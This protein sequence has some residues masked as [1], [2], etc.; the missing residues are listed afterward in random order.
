MAELKAV[1]L[2][3]L[4]EGQYNNSLKTITLDSKFDWFL[5]P[6]FRKLREEF[7]PADYSEYLKEKN[8]KVVGTI[9]PP[10]TLTIQIQR[11]KKKVKVKD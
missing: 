9:S 7:V 3:E 11:G 1:G 4:D 6:D 10:T 8:D 5:S 2:V